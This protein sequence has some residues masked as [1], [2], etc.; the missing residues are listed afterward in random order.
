M[1][2]EILVIMKHI[3]KFNKLFESIVGSGYE[4]EFMDLL[5]TSI[6]EYY[7]GEEEQV[8]LTDGGGSIS[9]KFE[10]LEESNWA[11]I[12]LNI[13]DSR[14]KVSPIFKGTVNFTP[15]FKED[16]EELLFLSQVGALDVETA[17][18]VKLFLESIVVTLEFTITVEMTD[19]LAEYWE[20][21]EQPQTFEYTVD[22]VLEIAKKSKGEEVSSFK[23]A[24]KRFL[25]SKFWEFES[26]PEISLGYAQSDFNRKFSNKQRLFY[27][28]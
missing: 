18:I 5:L 3:L 6:L 19:R 28:E 4:E 23:N 27:D 26:D 15:V 8:S 2:G 10:Y 24:F 9:C 17:S 21:Q 16:N 22:Q 13:A 25:S 12:Y 7:E 20:W 1:V 14:F 11:K